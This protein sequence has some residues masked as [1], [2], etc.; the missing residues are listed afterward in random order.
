MQDSRGQG[1]PLNNITLHELENMDYSFFAE[2]R[3]ELLNLKPAAYLHEF[4]ERNVAA[5]V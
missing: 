4:L 5:T 1:E 3:T 2:H